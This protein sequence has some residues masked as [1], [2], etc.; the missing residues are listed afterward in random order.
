MVAQP[1]SSKIGAAR[2]P[3]SSLIPFRLDLRSVRLRV[4]SSGWASN[5][6]TPSRSVRS[7][8]SRSKVGTG[9]PD[10]NATGPPGSSWNDRVGGRSARPPAGTRLHADA[11]SG[12]VRQAARKRA[13]HELGIKLPPRYGAHLFGALAPHKEALGA[14]DVPRS[15]RCPYLATKTVV[16]G[17]H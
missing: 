3:S 15:A 17:R 11:I 12:S 8:G 5:R 10:W 9:W 6:Q 2:N 4:V 14:V 16:A 13:R 7:L 1:E